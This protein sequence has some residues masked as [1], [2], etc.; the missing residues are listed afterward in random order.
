MKVH[1][2]TLW[3]AEAVLFVCTLNTRLN[4]VGS[5]LGPALDADRDARREVTHTL[6]PY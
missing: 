3:Y 1:H 4:D 2:G 6:K 5:V